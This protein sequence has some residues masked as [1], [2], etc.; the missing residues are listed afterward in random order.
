M[1]QE[2][3]IVETAEQRRKRLEQELAEVKAQEKAE[4]QAKRLDYE[5]KR[6]EVVKELVSEAKGLNE[7]LQAFKNKA[8]KTMNEF[9]ELAS[10]YGDI[11]T[12]SRGGFS[13]RNNDLNLKATLRRNMTHEYDERADKAMA[14]INDFLASTVKKKDQQAYV[15]IKTLLERNAKGDLKPDRVAS[16]LK[17]RDNYNDERWTKALDL[18]EE[19]YSP[20][21]VSFNVEFY[22]VDGIGKE[23]PICLTF[24]SL[25]VEETLFKN[26]S[27]ETTA[28]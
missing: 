2:K 28:S 24:A 8:L 15:T 25:P 19:S 18:L 6:N 12:N 27:E 21:Q 10:E 22:E 5:K 1:A 11:R 26:A 20:R 16:L 23:Q 7:Q 9:S 13:L 3:V 4:K 14:L 17:I